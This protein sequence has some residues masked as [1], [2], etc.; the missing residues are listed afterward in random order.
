MCK[1]KSEPELAQ[2]QGLHPVKFDSVDVTV[3]LTTTSHGHPS[4]CCKEYT[5]HGPHAL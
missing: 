5:S 2:A 1:R 3:D 4:L